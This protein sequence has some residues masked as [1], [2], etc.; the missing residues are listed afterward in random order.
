MA[1][2]ILAR[3]QI[4][5]I[6]G[7]KLGWIHVVEHEGSRTVTSIVGQEDYRVGKADK[8]I[9]ECTSMNKLEFQLRKHLGQLSNVTVLAFSSYFIT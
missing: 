6:V 4:F 8:K 9:Q 3:R 7:G 1:L 5:I 2:I